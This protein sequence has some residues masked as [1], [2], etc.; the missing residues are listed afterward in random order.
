MRGD[1]IKKKKKR[2]KKLSKLKRQ[3][4]HFTVKKTKNKKNKEANYYFSAF[5]GNKITSLFFR[6]HQG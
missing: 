2:N 6:I 1:E 4:G 3:Y 5:K